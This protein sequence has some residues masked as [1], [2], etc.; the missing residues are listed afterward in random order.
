LV[1][2]QYRQSEVSEEARFSR[3]AVVHASGWCSIISVSLINIRSDGLLCWCLAKRQ[4]RKSVK[5]QSSGLKS[6]FRRFARSHVE[7]ISLDIASRDLPK[8]HMVLGVEA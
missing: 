1:Y 6:E 2:I 3:L 8:Q 4:C 5:S 7:A